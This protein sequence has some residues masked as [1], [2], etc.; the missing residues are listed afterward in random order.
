MVWLP[1]LLSRMDSDAFSSC[2][3]CVQFYMSGLFSILW[4]EKRK[5]ERQ[6]A[7]LG[8]CSS[9]PT[10]ASGPPQ[11]PFTNHSHL[12]SLSVEG[13]SLFFVWLPFWKTFIKPQ[14]LPFGRFLCC[15][16]CCVK[17]KR[18]IWRVSRGKVGKYNMTAPRRLTHTQ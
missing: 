16:A 7:H 12:P 2:Q 8:M 9:S 13:P 3:C 10:S 11:L 1:V 4:K 6:T 5:A 18:Q 17:G 14:T 15:V